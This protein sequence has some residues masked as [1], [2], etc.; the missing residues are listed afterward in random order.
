MR[1]YLKDE[2]Y[3]WKLWNQADRYVQAAEALAR[4]TNLDFTSFEIC[5]NVDL[6]TILMDYESFFF[7][8]FN[9]YPK[10]SKRVAGSKYYI[11]I[12]KGQSEVK[13]P[14]RRSESETRKK[15]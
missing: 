4:E 15:P 8:K 9:K 10:I 14:K 13:Q 12:S 6:D 2:G 5:D 11:N 7:V 1:N 3:I